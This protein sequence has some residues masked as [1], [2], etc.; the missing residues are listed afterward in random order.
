MT[1][2][3]SNAF[4]SL[5]E[6]QKLMEQRHLIPGPAGQLELYFNPIE[7]PA[8]TAFI[9][10]H[11]HSLKGG[12]MTNKVVTTFTK[13][14]SELGHPTVRFNFRS[15]GQSTGEFDGGHGEVEDVR[16]IIDWLKQTQNISRFLLGGFSFGAFVAALTSHH[17][18]QQQTP[19]QH[20]LLVAPPLSYPEFSQLHIAAPQAW[21][22]IVAGADEVVS[23]PTTLA[24]L[25]EQPAPYAFLNVEGAS[26]FFHGQ[27][28]TLRNFIVEQ[29]ESKD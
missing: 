25:G 20:L 21:S 1:D 7:T 16:C 12:S 15:V 2:V 19:I 17:F 22:L 14:F 24:W 13:A 28:I 29:F 18:E 3:D 4:S 9:M 5:I 26:H 6:Q 23:T 10:C 11:P 27:L 8:D